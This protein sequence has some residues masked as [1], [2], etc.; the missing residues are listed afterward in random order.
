MAAGKSLPKSVAWPLKT[1]AQLLR[2]NLRFR[3]FDLTE[4]GQTIWMIFDPT[5]K[6]KNIPK[7]LAKITSNGVAIL[8]DAQ[9]GR[10]RE[11]I[12]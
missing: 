3:T 6:E 9:K 5:S 4:D 1:I 11:I 10:G 12:K 2:Q 8:I 7:V